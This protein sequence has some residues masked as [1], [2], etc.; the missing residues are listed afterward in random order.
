MKRT[1]V[2]LRQTLSDADFVDADDVMISRVRCDSRLVKPGDA[3]AA[4]VGT[5]FDGHHFVDDAVS[6]GASAVILQH[7]ID[8]LPVPQ[9]IVN[10]PSAA[11]AKLSM[12]VH[13]FP[14]AAVTT[15]GITGTNGKTTTT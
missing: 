3:F 15:A 12:A 1:M 10:D 4:I 2:S 7:R 6:R 9:C 14:S 8:G 13:G 11:F 5:A